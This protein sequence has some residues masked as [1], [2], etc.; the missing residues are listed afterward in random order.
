MLD[1]TDQEGCL[2]IENLI[3]SRRFRLLHLQ[4][5]KQSGPA[6]VQHR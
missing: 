3:I 1:K 4:Q 6:S 2:A 5:L